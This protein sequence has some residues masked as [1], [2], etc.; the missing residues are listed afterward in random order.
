MAGNGKFGPLDP[1]CFL[2]VVPLVIVAV[3]LV[4]SD[5]AV[6]SIVPILLAGLIML[7]DS[8]ANRRPS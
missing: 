8:W 1:F 7:G 6:F 5:L 4:I 2:A 3:V